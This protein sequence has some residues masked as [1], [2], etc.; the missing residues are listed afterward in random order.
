MAEYLLPQIMHYVLANGFK[1]Q[2]PPVLEG[3]LKKIGKQ[4]QDRNKHDS[5]VP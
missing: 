2:H 4:E 5:L 1:D 3:Q